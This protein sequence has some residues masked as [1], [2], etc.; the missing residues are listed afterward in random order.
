VQGMADGQIAFGG[1]NEQRAQDAEV[2]GGVV[3]C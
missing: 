1:V 2:V 3:V